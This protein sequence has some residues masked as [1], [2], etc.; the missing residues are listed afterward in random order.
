M[1]FFQKNLKYSVIIIVIVA[2]IFISL[3]L[4]DNPV[5]SL[6]LSV[7]SPFLKTTHL[8]SG[9]VKGLTDFLGS[10]GDLKSENERLMEENQAFLAENNRL[11]DVEK[12]N[13]DLRR[14]LDLAP[15]DDFNL[16]ASYIIGQ[17]PQGLGN[18]FLIDKGGDSGIRTGMPAIVSNGILVGRVSEVHPTSAK[19]IL[20]TDP[21][22]AVNAEVQNTGAKGIIRG[23]YGLGIKMDMVSQTEVLNEGDTVITSGLGSRMPRGIT[24]GKIGKVSQSANK[25]FQEASV[26]PA[27]DFSEL[28]IVFIVKQ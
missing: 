2:V 9:G 19:V 13:Q 25:L 6:V 11:K 22:S 1:S 26:I 27:V 3:R 17:D 15:C 18:Y 7:S 5:K 4:P 16:E 10:I 8:F 24:I 20:I 14:Q 21:E 23:E 28:R 12:E